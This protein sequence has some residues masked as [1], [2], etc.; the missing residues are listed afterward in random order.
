[1]AQSNAEDNSSTIVINCY[2]KV[3]REINFTWSWQRQEVRRPLE[4][5]ELE[6]D[7]PRVLPRASLVA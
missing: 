6:E 3:V 1:M 2:P 4:G 7:A 5:A